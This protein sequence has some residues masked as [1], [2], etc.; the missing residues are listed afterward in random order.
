LISYCL[1]CCSLIYNADD[2]FEFVEDVVTAVKDLFEHGALVHGF[3]FDDVL[4]DEVDLV[5]ELAVVDVVL[6]LVDQEGLSDPEVETHV[7]QGHCLEGQQELLEGDQAHA[8]GELAEVRTHLLVRLHEL[9]YPL[10]V[11]EELLLLAV[12]ETLELAVHLLAV[13][14]HAQHLTR[15]LEFVPHGLA[16]LG[17]QAQ[18]DAQMD[19]VALVQHRQVLETVDR[20]E[21]GIRGRLEFAL[22]D[23]E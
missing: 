4:V 22:P 1:F 16:R 14:D 10:E 6:Q 19:E 11:A 12:L 20:V 18:H 21:Q 2:F 23:V 3:C 15:V 17:Q 9:A 7:L 13:L 5:V 8:L